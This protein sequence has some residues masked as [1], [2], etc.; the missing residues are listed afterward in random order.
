M[1]KNNHIR[2]LPGIKKVSVCEVGK[3]GGEMLNGKF[4]MQSTFYEL[5]VTGIGSLKVLSQIEDGQIIYTTSASF[6]L[7]DLGCF[8]YQSYLSQQ[9]FVFLFED[10]KGNRYIAG[11][12][13]RPFPT[14]TIEKRFGDTPTDQ[15]ILN[16]E[17]NLRDTN[18]LFEVL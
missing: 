18:G 13:E 2:A 17:F 12:R 15:R 8:D 3:Y 4:W 9:S 14:L 5:P 11:N 10:V 7:P 1:S 6:K 16:I